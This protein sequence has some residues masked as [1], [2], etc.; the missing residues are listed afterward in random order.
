[1]SKN[2][3]VRIFQTII[4]VL[5]AVFNPKLA[6]EIFKGDARNETG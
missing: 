6:Q 3:I 5:V 2:I 4:I 1:M